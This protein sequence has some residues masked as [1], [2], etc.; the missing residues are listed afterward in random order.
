MRAKLASERLNNLEYK[1]KLIDESEKKKKASKEDVISENKSESDSSSFSLDELQLDSPNRR[2]SKARHSM[3]KGMQQT[4]IFD[5]AKL[6]QITLGK[7][8]SEQTDRSETS[9][10]TEYLR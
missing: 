4:S 10:D 5:R 8:E 1:G 7:V 6:K 9:K 2:V 3:F